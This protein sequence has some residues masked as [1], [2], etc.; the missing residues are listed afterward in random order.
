MQIKGQ[1]AVPGLEAVNKAN[2]KNNSMHHVCRNPCNR[3]DL[4]KANFHFSNLACYRVAAPLVLAGAVQSFEIL[5]N[6][7]QGPSLL[8]WTVS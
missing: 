7:Q 5:L 1:D 4:L 3:R 8:L 6:L 2:W